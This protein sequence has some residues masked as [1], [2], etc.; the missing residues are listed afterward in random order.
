M[1]LLRAYFVL[2]TVI[3]NLHLSDRHTRLMDPI[4]ILMNDA[5]MA[6]YPANIDALAR[7]G[8]LFDDN[9]FPFVARQ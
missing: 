6:Q 4:Q 2:T 5:K 9:V 7:P 3:I 8:C 1:F